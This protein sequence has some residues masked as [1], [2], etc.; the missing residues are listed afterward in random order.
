MNDISTFEDIQALV[1]TFYG[2]VQQ[3]D[4]IGPVFNSKIQNRWPEHLAKMYRFWESILLDNH[5][6]SGRPF[7]PHALLPV[8][9]T[10]FNRWLTL[11]TATVDSLFVGPIAEEAKERAAK[12]AAMFHYKIEY[13]KNN[14]I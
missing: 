14:T 12:M 7:P 10:H 11:F 2:K 8:D 6:Y 3:D 9:A 5:T 1:N 4:Y 13:I